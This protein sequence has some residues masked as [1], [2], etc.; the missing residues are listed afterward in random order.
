MRFYL[1][2]LLLLLIIFAG[3]KKDKVRPDYPVGSN[4]HVNSWVLDSMRIYYYWSNSLPAKPDLRK[5]P[6]DFFTSV[7]HPSDRFSILVNRTQPSSYLPGLITAFGLDLVSIEKDGALQTYV[8][9]VVPKSGAALSGIK[10]GDKISSINDV[11]ITKGNALQLVNEAITKGQLRLKVDPGQASINLVATYPIED[12]VHRYSIFESGGV[13]TAYLFLNSFR[14]SSI[15]Q[16]KNIFNEFKTANAKELIL[17]LRYNGGGEVSVAAFLATLIAPIKGT[18]IFAE[19]RGNAKAGTKQHNFDKELSYI[20]YRVDQ[21][22]TYRLPLRRLYILTGKHTA[23]SAEMLANNLSPYVEVIRIGEQTLGKDMA[24]FEIKDTRNPVQ[25][26]NW[27]IHP[28]VYKLYNSKGQGNYDEG[29]TPTLDIN[30]LQ[31]IPLKPLGDEADPLIA[32]ALKSISGKQIALSI[33]LNKISDI[34]VQMDT[35]TTLDA[36]SRVN[37]LHR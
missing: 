35:R 7:K 25:V 3:C 5:L 23:S 17:D 37:Y 9:L 11:Q 18:D 19:Y 2:S 24:S 27:I 33:S 21:L 22:V 30:E 26:E 36:Q 31:S 13:K 20:S 12:P 6:L 29:L 28:L 16:F 34:V 15:N 8:T 32:A 10:R 4:E 14:S 1:S